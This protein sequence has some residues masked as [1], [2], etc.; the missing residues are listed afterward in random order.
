[1]N[2]PIRT[3]LLTLTAVL[4][5]VAS[6]GKQEEQ[7]V[8][9]LPA[10]IESI[11]PAGAALTKMPVNFTFDTAGQ[12][13]WFNGELLFTNNNFNPRERSMTMKLD[14][15]GNL[16]VIRDYNGVT[17]CIYNSGGGTFYCCEM[18][19]HR[20]I[21]MDAQGTV[22]RTIA[23]SFNGKR[24][25]GPNDMTID[26]HGGIYFTDSHFSPGEE[27]I[28]DRPMVIYIRPGA[29]PVC[30]IDDINFPNGLEL[31]LDGKIL[32]V[33]NTNGDDK[34]RNIF[35]YDVQPDG[36][37]ANKRIFA[38]LQLTPENE[39]NPNGVSGADGTAVD[40]A[41]NL[42]VATT[43]GIGIQIFSPDGAHIGNIPCPVA[44][45]N[46]SFGGEDMKTLYVSALDGVY[47]MPVL[48][49]GKNP[50]MR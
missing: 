42:Y 49:P 28:Q 13:C 20:V 47:S 6:C 8:V 9:D 35:A 45:N 24:L 48:I 16:S 31:S 7:P 4:L 14:T 23:S 39:S 41:G 17:T 3:T 5:T 21:E 33:V 37:V 10:G 27:L 34:G 18:V 26:A 22:L 30:V 29:D 44:C 43:Q 11:V 12:P 50:P 32:Y 38:E 46:L 36:T 19:G 40:T 1:M 2:L 25:D 15:Q